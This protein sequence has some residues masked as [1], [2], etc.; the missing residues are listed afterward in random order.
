M[1]EDL[2]IGTSTGY[3]IYHYH[4]S[5]C[6]RE[7]CYATVLFVGIYL[8][9]QSFRPKNLSVVA[10]SRESV[11]I[12]PNPLDDTIRQLNR[13][14][15]LECNKAI[16][17]SLREKYRSR[18]SKSSLI[19]ESLISHMAYFRDLLLELN[20]VP[21]LFGGTLLGKLFSSCIKQTVDHRW[22]CRMVS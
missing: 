2:I 1:N 22:L 16:S 17:K 8:I 9:I 21:F 3:Q 10:V 11:L 4:L 12:V 20:I 7:Y 19:D 6:F 14:Q 15:F 13:S 18:Y 5:L